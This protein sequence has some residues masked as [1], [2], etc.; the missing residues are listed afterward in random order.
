MSGEV[1]VVT[2]GKGGVGKT[3]TAVNVAIALRQA[4]HS[5]ALVDGDL[6]M[7][8]VGAF[9]SLDGETTLHDVL[10]ARATTAEAIVE[11]DEGL[12]VVPGDRSLEG[13]ADA[14]P[15]R[16]REVLAELKA[17]YQ[18]VL[19]DTGGGLTYEG[20]YPMELADE[21]LLVTSTVPAA[22]TD[23][24]KSLRLAD[25]LDVPVR[26]VVVTHTDGDA[27]PESIASELDVDL[28]GD[29]PTDDAVVESVRK[30]QPVAAYAPESPAAAA[31]YRLA[32]RLSDADTAELEP[33]EL[34]GTPPKSEDETERDI[35]A[36]EPTEDEIDDAA[37]ENGTE[38][39]NETEPSEG[40]AEDASST[41]GSA[42]TNDHA[43]SGSNVD[44]ETDAT[45]AGEASTETAPAAEVAADT[46]SETG[47]DAR[48][49]ET[50][51]H[52]SSES[53]DGFF[54]RLLGRFR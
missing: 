50:K 52:A 44:G 15:E 40:T 36:G 14:D 26:G 45:E 29:I 19:V 25:R 6:G 54:A 11:I 3:T 5:V 13:F 2:S 51:T 18:Y 38:E 30:R 48:D 8:N 53:E 12:G 37:T 1:F 32:E 39:P 22:I 16:L 23:T 41:S 47:S 10:A 35:E 27:N 9:L 46:G 4:G 31:Y 28:L 21:I 42:E 49:I 17:R 7:P 33:L 43:G 20:V 24:K 34:A